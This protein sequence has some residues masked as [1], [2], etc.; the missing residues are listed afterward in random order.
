MGDLLRDGYRIESETPFLQ[1]TRFGPKTYQYRLG[2]DGD[3][4]ACYKLDSAADRSAVTDRS[5]L[6]LAPVSAQG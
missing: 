5:C 2:R 3:S 6:P 1:Q 4:W